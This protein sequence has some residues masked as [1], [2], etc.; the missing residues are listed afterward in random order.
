VRLYSAPQLHCTIVAIPG[1]C[2]SDRRFSSPELCHNRTDPL[3]KPEPIAHGLI[4]LGAV[5]PF[6][7]RQRHHSIM[8]R[9][10][11][12]QRAIE[13]LFRPFPPEIEGVFVVVH[14]VSRFSLRRPQCGSLREG[15][16]SRTWP[17]FNAPH[18]AY[19]RE[20]RWSA[21]R[22]HQDQGLRGR[23]PLRGLVLG[24]RQFR[25]VSAGVLKGD[26]LAKRRGIGSSNRRFQPRSAT[27][28][29]RLSQPLLLR[30]Q[31]APAFDLGLVEL[32]NTSGPGRTSRRRQPAE[33]QVL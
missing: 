19:P 23:L 1:I 3:P 9:G 27:G 31:L 8:D 16:N 6:V 5:A 7:R 14:H 12:R 24:L 29:D 4:D 26:K 13:R 32:L 2:A 11:N 33:R 20:H 28:L 15:L 22:R 25:D 17:R 18:D 10:I 21:R 30:L